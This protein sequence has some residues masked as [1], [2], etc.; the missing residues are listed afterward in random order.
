MAP[1]L[2][3]LNRELAH[4]DSFFA[5]HRPLLELEL[6]VL[7][8][9]STVAP[10]S[11]STSTSLEKEE[12]QQQ[13]AAEE[14]DERK[15]AELEQEEVEAFGRELGFVSPSLTGEVRPAAAEEEMVQVVDLAEDGVTMIGKPYFVAAPSSTS[16]TTA[17]AEEDDSSSSS[18]SSLLPRTIYSQ[19]EEH[20]GNQD[21][22]YQYDT[23]LLGN[24]HTTP[25]SRSIS[26]YLALHQP[27]SPPPPPALPT[28]RQPPMSPKPS[29]SYSAKTLSEISFL[30]PFPSPASSASA[31]TTIPNLSNSDLD[32]LLTPLEPNWAYHLS[33][34]FLNSKSLGWRYRALRDWEGGMT[35]NE[36]READKVGLKVE[37][38]GVT[39]WNSVAGTWVRVPLPSVD[40]LGM[41]GW[42]EVDPIV[43]E[44][45][46]AEPSIAELLARRSMEKD[47]Q[48]VEM[49][50]TKRK[51][52]KKIKKHKYKKRRKAQQALRQRLGK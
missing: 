49:D 21:S 10:H 46:R 7:D 37:G 38:E 14:L 20:S 50:S 9:R 29:S 32:A 24:L 45:D 1:P 30:R 12:H 34:Q 23:F 27:F 13:L 19:P 36:S 8:R 35:T 31:S 33:D 18:S 48:V 39:V 6:A 43:R 15:I 41:E 44:E 26:R 52:K 51:R 22:Q 5:Q 4:L 47:E 16:A 17:V 25:P 40:E 3:H 42:T 2:P 11:H 28:R